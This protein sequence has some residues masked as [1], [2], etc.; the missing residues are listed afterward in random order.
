MD[1]HTNDLHREVK[2]F[3]AATGMGPSYFGQRATG[4]SKLVSRLER[5]G[6]VTL[7]TAEKIRKFISLNGLRASSGDPPVNL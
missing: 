3:L 4:D 7:P 2:A 5:G 6:T 1:R